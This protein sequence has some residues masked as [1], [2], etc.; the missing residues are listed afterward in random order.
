MKFKTY[1]KT[2]VAV[3]AFGVSATAAFADGHQMCTEDVRILAQPRDGLTTT[4]Q[5]ADEFR[6]LSGVGFQIDYLNE[7]DRRAKSRADASTIGKY[8]VYYVDEANLAQFAE[9]GWLVPLLDHYPA[10]FDFEDFDPVASQRPLMTALF[11]LRQF[12][13]AV[14]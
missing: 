14:T 6:E 9:P 3:A 11:G 12:K 2:T 13:V 10:E 5:F 7:G 8:N 4:E 1:L